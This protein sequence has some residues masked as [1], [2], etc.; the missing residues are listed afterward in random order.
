MGVH[1]FRL[2]MHRLLRSLTDL[3]ERN[4]LP[5]HGGLITARIMN[6]MRLPIAFVPLILA[7]TV[8]MCAQDHKSPHWGYDGDEGPDH[9]GELSPQFAL[10]QSGHR[11]SPIDIRNPR[12]ADLPPL[13][14]DFKPSPLHIIDNGHTIQINYAPGS[15]LRV[16]D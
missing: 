4:F 10:C 2:A 3:V 8:T 7:L 11:Q 16:G 13:Q 5:L 14:M 12:K 9:W 1:T 6:P 15:I